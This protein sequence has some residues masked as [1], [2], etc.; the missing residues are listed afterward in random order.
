MPPPFSDYAMGAIYFL[1]MRAYKKIVNYTF[2]IYF[3]L[4]NIA[5]Y[6]QPL[7]HTLMQKLYAYVDVIGYEEEKSPCLP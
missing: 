1:S 6:I 7:S 4:N 3:I 5:S 2:N